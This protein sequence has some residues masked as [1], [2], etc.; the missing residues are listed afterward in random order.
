MRDACTRAHI[1]HTA[2]WESL[3]AAHRILVSKVAIQDVSENLSVPVW[4]CAGHAMAIQETLQVSR[5]HPCADG[6]AETLSP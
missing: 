4:M 2:P 5:E 1:L 3:L 6:L